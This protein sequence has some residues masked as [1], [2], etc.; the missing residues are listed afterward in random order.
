MIPVMIDEASSHRMTLQRGDPVPHF[1]VA[2]THGRVVEY[3]TIWQHRNLVLVALSEADSASSREYVSQ[4]ET[5]FSA[6]HSNETD[7]VITRGAVAG[8][9][10]PAVLIADRWGELVHVAGA[11]DVANLPRLPEILEWVAY[12]QTRCPKCEGETK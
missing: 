9:A 11:S 6:F 12:L 8:V 4:Y 2:T 1:R 7:C 10:P 5:G 3:S